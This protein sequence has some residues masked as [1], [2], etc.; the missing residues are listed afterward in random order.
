[1]AI[2]KTMPR[3]NKN[4]LDHIA[5]VKHTLAKT[6]PTSNRELWE[7][8]FQEGMKGCIHACRN[9]DDSKGYA[10]SSYAMQC[11][12]GE[13]L[14]YIRDRLHPIRPN[15]KH[16]N[17]Y[18]FASM[19]YKINFHNGSFCFLQD[20]IAAPSVDPQVEAIRS[21]LEKLDKDDPKA[22]QSVRLTIGGGDMMHKE[23]AILIGVKPATVRQ[24]VKRGVMKL[25]KILEIAS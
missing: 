15:R 20:T 1:M 23:A 4:P 24:R 5:L 3:S 2:L 8:L 13:I 17:V 25:K 19:D 14:H 7:D 21:A 22:A 11:I 18:S 10:F 16:G 6:F 9:F 12:R